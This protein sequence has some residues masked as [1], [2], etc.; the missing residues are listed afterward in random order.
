M[1]REGLS[2]TVY[3]AAN[4]DGSPTGI[5]WGISPAEVID[6]SALGVDP[7]LA[8][9][10]TRFAVGALD[11]RDHNDVHFTP[12][13]SASAIQFPGAENAKQ[14]LMDVR[15]VPPAKLEGYD[16]PAMTLGWEPANQP[17]PTQRRYRITNP[18][19]CANAANAVA[20][21]NYVDL[22]YSS[23]Y[24][25]LVHLIATLRNE[26]IDP[27]RSQT[28][29]AE[30]WLRR[31][32]AGCLGP[33]HGREPADSS[34]RRHQGRRAAPDAGVQGHDLVHHAAAWPR[35]QTELSGVAPNAP[36]KLL[37][38]HGS[39]AVRAGVFGLSPGRLC[40]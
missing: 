27:D 7:F 40:N 26:S 10:N 6:L 21:Q 29:R 36:C 1:R 2:R 34:D 23:G 30:A 32:A 37:F 14:G 18:A 24:F 35:A 8:P 38:L 17:P 20:D 31:K 28:V 9:G 33:C 22:L 16:E 3:V 11:L 4:F 39:V 5:P 25:N 13:F 15:W 12:T 19:E